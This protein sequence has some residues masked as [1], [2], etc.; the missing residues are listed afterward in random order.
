MD[1]AIVAAI[2]LPIMALCCIVIKKRAKE[3]NGK[4]DA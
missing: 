4:K 2:L 1:T 3:E